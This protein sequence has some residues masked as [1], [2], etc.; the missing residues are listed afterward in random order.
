[1]APRL[2]SVGHA[3]QRKSLKAKPYHE[4]ARQQKQL[5]NHQ[6]DAEAE[7]AELNN[8]LSQLVQEAS[9]ENQSSKSDE[10]SHKRSNHG[11]SDHEEF[12]RV[13]IQSITMALVSDLSDS[14]N[15]SLRGNGSLYGSNKL[16]IF[17]DLNV[18]P[19][20]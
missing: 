10:S 18:P 9:L 14:S 8:E 17:T 6:A 19:E 1:M 15:S 7:S 4:R 16:G 12:N 20:L 2:A 3:R 5:R 13:V 11:G